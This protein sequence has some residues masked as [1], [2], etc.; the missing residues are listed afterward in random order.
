MPRPDEVKL[1]AGYL[2]IAYSITTWER[3][4]ADPIVDEVVRSVWPDDKR[5][6]D[7]DPEHPLLSDAS[8]LRLMIGK[9]GKRNAQKF[10]STQD[11]LLSPKYVEDLLEKGF[12]SKKGL[13]ILRVRFIFPKNA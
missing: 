13:Y 12:E 5:D 6:I 3:G 4:W 8:P 1:M 7:C 11:F 2:T 9:H 10:R